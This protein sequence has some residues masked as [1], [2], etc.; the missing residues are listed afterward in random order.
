[1]IKKQY[2]NIE[3][4]ARYYSIGNFDKNTQYLIIAFHGYGQLASYFINNFENL[5][6][7]VFVI[8]PEGLHRFYLNGMSGRVG[9]S[10]MTKED[11]LI[12][13]ENQSSYINSLLAQFGDLKSENIKLIVLGFSQGVSTAIRWMSKSKYKPSSFIAWAGSYPIDL[14]DIEIRNALGDVNTMQIFGKQDPYFNEEAKNEMENWLK[15][16]TVEVNKFEFDG[17]HKIDRDFLKEMVNEQI[18]NKEENE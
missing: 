10:W 16:H 5:G 7:H 3:V 15:K 6:E 18:I 11:R 2:L 4:K 9:A 14:S 12:D 1:M 8:V 13:I 17:G